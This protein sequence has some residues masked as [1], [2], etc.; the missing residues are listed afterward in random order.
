MDM[1]IAAATRRTRKSG[2][3][4][5]NTKVTKKVESSDE[6][7]SDSGSITRCVCGEAHNVG[8]MVQCEQCEVWQHCNCMGLSQDKLPKH[9]YCDKCKPENHQTIKTST[10]RSKRSYNA[11][12]LVNNN[13]SPSISNSEDDS[14]NKKKRRKRNDGSPSFIPFT[15]TVDDTIIS[16]PIIQSE[17]VLIES[18]PPRKKSPTKPPHQKSNSTPQQQLLDDFASPTIS[19]YWNFSDGR[20]VRESSPPAK[21]KYPNPKMSFSDMSKRAKQLLECISKLQ[22]ENSSTALN[23]TPPSLSSSSSSSDHFQTNNTSRPRSLSTCSSS[24][25]L[26]SASTLPLI[27]NSLLTDS[28]STPIPYIK[29]ESSMEILDRVSKQIIQ[30]Q[31]K[32]ELSK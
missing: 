21:V 11:S 12:G 13:S 2:T 7:S 8:L 19:T 31:R 18:L 5:R 24:S 6:E 27:D 16:D 25:S 22:A 4:K 9:Y 10:G 20:P 14:H 32:F 15:T 28:P 30:F 26:S 17:D 3:N 23:D 1:S 29:E